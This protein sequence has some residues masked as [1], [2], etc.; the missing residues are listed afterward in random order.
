MF[1]KIIYIN[2]E[3]A[4][5]KVK[6]GAQLV[7]NLMNLH[8]IF[9]DD[10]KKILGEIDDISEDTVKARFLGE[11]QNNRFVGGVIRKPNLNATVRIITPEEMNLIV[12]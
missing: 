9:E 1:E 11:F 8:V 7:T 2:D 6:E 5:I 3:G 12:G 10:K 4:S